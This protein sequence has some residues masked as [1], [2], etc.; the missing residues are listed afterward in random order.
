[1]MSAFMSQ[2]YCWR[3]FLVRHYGL[4]M[5]IYDTPVNTLTGEA[6]SLAEY[7]GQTIL[8]VNVASKCGLTPQYT[9]S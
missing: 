2:D 8:V 6:S 3:H 5:T 4:F 1:M 9:G 7:Q